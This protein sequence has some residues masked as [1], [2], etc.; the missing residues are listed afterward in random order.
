MAVNDKIRIFC[1][2]T[3]TQHSFPIGISLR[4]ISKQ[5]DT[6]TTCQVISARV[7]CVNE[8][9]NFRL[10]NSKDIEFITLC[11]PAGMRTYIRSLTFILYKAIKDLYPE[12]ELTVEHPVSKGMFCQ[13]VIN[14]KPI[15]QTH[16]DAIKKRMREIVDADIP[17]VRKE[18]RNEE[19]A[20][21]FEK[22]GCRDKVLLLKT[23]QDLYSIYYTLDKLP[24]VYYGSLVPST[25]YVKV[26]DLILI[27][28]GILLIP[29]KKDNPDVT[30][31]P[32]MQSKLL[33]SFDDQNQF[34][35][36]IRLSNVG[37]LNSAV[38]R[39]LASKII[40]L[41]EALQE[42]RIIEIADAIA[43]RKGTRVVL[44]S[45]P[46]SSGKT[47][48]TKRLEVQLWANLRLPVALS[49]DDYYVNRINSPKDEKG[50]HDYE[51]LHAIDIHQFNTDVEKLLNGE[52]VMM[53][54]YNF[55]KGE[56]E[57]KGNKI[58]LRPEELLI[59]EGIHALNPAI[60]DTISDE[61][62]CKVY[63]SALT[64]ISLDNHNYIPTTDN[65]LLRRIVRD[66]K[67]RAHSAKDTI[68]RWAS[69][70]RGEDK[71]IFPYQE[72]ADMMFNSAMIY[73]LAVLKRYAEPILQEVP[74]NCPEYAEAARL[75]RFLRYISPI[76]DEELPPTSLLRE[77]FGGSSFRY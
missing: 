40:K 73:E 46:S 42:R 11:D 9:L 12:G 48:F 13:I 31:T 29:P 63:A 30:E 4:E 77:F 53:P 15:E 3:Q 41:S 62:K 59:I 64:T 57:Y 47:T 27:S 20:V 54:T 56:R 43:A 35:K 38:Q 37:Q 16:V 19:A 49:M 76:Y 24:D 74:R 52:E 5:I 2:N 1:V 72:N 10:Y 39:G 60:L 68:A 26:F 75:L 70:R 14:G 67:Y 22:M 51:S 50:D 17:F 36:V 61:K 44:I 8:G 21:L 25:G 6:G 28:N 34:N 58:R 18:A 55:A 66:Y 65:R 69:V 71:W 23:S 45:G 33:K 7:N 32:V